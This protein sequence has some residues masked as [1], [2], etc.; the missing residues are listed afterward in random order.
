[1]PRLLTK[2]Q[3]EKVVSHT[4]TELSLPLAKTEERMAAVRDMIGPR[5]VENLYVYDD[6]HK[7]LVLAEQLR[8]A[9]S[10]LLNSPAT[11]SASFDA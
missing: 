10:S 3:I 7:V 9:T 1:M 6:V 8:E 11:L 5:S 2:A 4:Y